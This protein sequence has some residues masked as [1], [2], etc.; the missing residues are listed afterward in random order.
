MSVNTRIDNFL[1]DV[2]DVLGRGPHILSIIQQILNDTTNLSLPLHFELNQI[3]DLQCDKT[4]LNKTL[5][6]VIF[7]G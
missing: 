4:L 1:E 7:S 5:H 3:V 6:Y 2:N